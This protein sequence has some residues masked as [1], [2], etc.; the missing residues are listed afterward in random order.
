[1]P[2]NSRPAPH[3]LT[4]PAASSKGSSTPSTGRDGLLRHND[5]TS[6]DP[7]P[8]TPRQAVA[9]A[10]EIE[11]GRWPVCPAASAVRLNSKHH[12]SINSPLAMDARQ[13]SERLQAGGTRE[14][15]IS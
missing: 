2:S 5:D 3:G 7:F 10:P 11:V 14:C 9:S 1:G 13:G 6:E 12:M 8:M 4:R 15:V